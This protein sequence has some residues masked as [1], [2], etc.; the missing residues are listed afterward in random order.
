M[1]PVFVDSNI[2]L[3]VI[4][5]G[6]EFSGWSQEQLIA[7]GD[8]APLIINSIV[9]AEI[10]VNFAAI[11]DVF[12]F[13]GPHLVVE[14]MPLEAAFAAGKAFRA[15]RERGGLRRSPLPDFFIG[16]HAA[17]RGFRLLTRDAR[18]FRGYFPR[19]EIIVPG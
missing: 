13:L 4:D 6:S 10:S 18:R 12:D 19:L 3:D 11:E 16:A 1:T 7:L 2:L 9:F 17:V 5:P 8:A 15:Y 14:E